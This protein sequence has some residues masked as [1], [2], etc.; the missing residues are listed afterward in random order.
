MLLVFAGNEFCASFVSTVEPL[1]ATGRSTNPTKSLCDKY[2]FNT[3]LTRSKSLV[4]VA[5]SPYALL[6]AEN[7]MGENTTCWKNFLRNCIQ[8]KTL[9][10]PELVEKDANKISQFRQN[11][12]SRLFQ[13]DPCQ[14]T[15][16]LQFPSSPPPDQVASK[17][18]LAAPPEDTPGN[19]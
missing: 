6:H 1:D 15:Q 8:N 7:L 9:I 4:V 5:G 18:V 10:I 3:V 13:P 19:D 11:L 2:V 12:E 16:S 14:L 17:K